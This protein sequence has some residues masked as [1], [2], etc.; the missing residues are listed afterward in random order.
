VYTNAQAGRNNLDRLHKLA[1]ENSVAFKI[2]YNEEHSKH[3]NNENFNG[4]RDY[5]PPFEV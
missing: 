1:K 2:A 5:V 3:F 4:D